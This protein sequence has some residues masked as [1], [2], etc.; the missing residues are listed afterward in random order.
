MRFL[1]YLLLVLGF[2]GT[3]YHGLAA[4]KTK[5]LVMA[6][7]LQQIQVGQSYGSQDV[8]KSVRGAVDDMIKDSEWYLSCATGM[9][10]GG[11]LVGIGSSQRKVTN[12]RT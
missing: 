6:K 1:G 10:I 2:A 11:V 8:V 9:L 7:P 12:E 4:R 3:W 5:G